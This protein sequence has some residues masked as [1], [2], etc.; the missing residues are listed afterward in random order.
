MKF[1]LL[2]L[3]LSL[4]RADE[5]I[6]FS[7]LS[8]F[9]GQM[10]AGKSSIARLVDY[11]LGG[12]IQLSPALQAEFVSATLTVELERATV[13]I[14]RA[15]DAA[16]VFTSWED[17]QGPYSVVIPARVAAGEV[18]PETGVETLS[19]LIFWLSEI[20]PPRVRKS[21]AKA[22]SK[23]VRLSLRDLLWYCYLDQDHIDSSFF[24][25]E[26][27]AEF[28]M[29]LKSRDVIRYVIGY[30]DERVA[31]LEAE[32]D[33]LRANRTARVASIDSLS[34]ALAEVGIESEAQ[35][36]ERESGLR[37]SIVKVNAE[38]EVLRKGRREEQT[39]HAIDELAKMARSL[40]ADIAKLDLD[41]EEL[42][43]MRDRHVRHRNEIDMLRL[44]FR[45]SAE[46]REILGD[47]AFNACP[48]CTQALPVRP[49]QC[50]EVCGQEDL[51]DLAD[52]AEVAALE[53][54]I[55]SRQA[56]LKE[57]IAAIDSN[58][59][60]MRARRSGLLQTKGKAE[61]DINRAIAEQDSAFLSMS[62]LK[63]RKRAALEAELASIAWLLR[64]PLLLQQQREALAQI[65]ALEQA[66]REALKEARTKAEADR[67]SLDRFAGY[68]LDCLVLS[69]VPGIQRNDHVE[70]NPPDF[71]PAILSAD[72]SDHTRSTFT[73]LSSGGKKTL[74]KC[75]FAI[76]LHRI[77]AQ[78]HAPLPELLIID[79]PMKNISEREN[80]AQFEGFYRMLYRLNA[81]ELRQTQFVL[82]DKEFFAPPDDLA[83]GVANRHMQPDSD[84]HQ[85]LIRY[86]RG[87]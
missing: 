3:N 68:F 18:I 72:P 41:T 29:R 60:K 77:A 53:A 80:K 52:P 36:A 87:K 66:K 73:S 38:L 45:R 85:P 15:R 55:A 62:L 40:G 74:F 24:Y 39:T 7:K 75:C 54:D 46:A 83:A 44:K 2:S 9:W 1:R 56:E 11:C 22:D 35:V 67:T 27:S 59:A 26:E 58:L 70:L 12:T 16:D 28:Y 47:V 42:R 65:V 14:E 23:I 76:A 21:K 86:Y 37:A 13:S 5:Q 20:N 31:D 81:G 34:K 4:R 84:E 50:C 48:R 6:E 78:L 57:A 10:G 25:L 32:L 19:D 69:G 61:A 51:V 30:H 43:A 82:I 71:Y 8:Y 49:A 33:Q 63:E 79:S 64:L 17:D